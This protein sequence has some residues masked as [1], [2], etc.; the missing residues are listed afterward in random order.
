MLHREKIFVIFETPFG[1][2]Y[3][4]KIT[5][6]EQ[7]AKIPLQ[8][9]VLVLQYLHYFSAIVDAIRS[10]GVKVSGVV[11]N[12]V[13]EIAA[14]YV[15]GCLSREQALHLACITGRALEEKCKK[16]VVLWY[17]MLDENKLDCSKSKFTFV[18]KYKQ[19]IESATAWS[20]VRLHPCS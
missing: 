6:H 10:T 13:S 15:D 18:N 3:S 7:L 5:N 1:S 4:W 11:S 14:G 16:G 20:V 12:G 2:L 9:L 19:C 17:T 8:L